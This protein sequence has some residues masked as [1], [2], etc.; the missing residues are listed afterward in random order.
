MNSREYDKLPIEAVQKVAPSVV[1][2]VISK[3]LPKIKGVY[4]MPGLPFGNPFMFGDVDGDK[5]K[6]KIGGGSGFIVHPDGL[7]LTNKHVVF[8]Q[9]AEYTVITTD[10]E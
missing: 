6:I 7:V 10:L 5:E 1:S 9:D 2:I 8:D 4:G 3:Y